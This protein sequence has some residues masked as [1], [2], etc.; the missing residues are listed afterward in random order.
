MPDSSV[1]IGFLDQI[2]F[3]ESSEAED[4][5]SYYVDLVELI[6]IN[7]FTFDDSASS[8]RPDFSM[9]FETMDGTIFTRYTSDSTY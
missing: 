8:I 7:S 2:A 4:L 6:Q 9:T 1:R 5:D 3:F